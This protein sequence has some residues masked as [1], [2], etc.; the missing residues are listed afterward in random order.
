MTA[1]LETARRER[2]VQP[3]EGE[4]REKNISVIIFFWY[5]CYTQVKCYARTMSLSKCGVSVALCKQ[6]LTAWSQVECWADGPR[7]N[8]AWCVLMKKESLLICVPHSEVYVCIVHLYLNLLVLKL[9]PTI[10]H[11][12]Y[13]NLWISS[14]LVGCC[15]LSFIC[16]CPLPCC[17]HLLVCECPSPIK[18]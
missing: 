15:C 8:H 1:G 6:T 12:L 2:K 7:S 17:L 13:L 3:Y 9:L 10:S 18:K 4:K 11:S 14:M 5:Y 16:F